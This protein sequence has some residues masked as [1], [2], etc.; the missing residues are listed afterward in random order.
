MTDDRTDEF[1]PLDLCNNGPCQA[2]QAPACSNQ[3]CPA[4][5]TEKCEGECVRAVKASLEPS[6]VPLF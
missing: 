3:F 1:T 5:C 4:C 6:D 2:P